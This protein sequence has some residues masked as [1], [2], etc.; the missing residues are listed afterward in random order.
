MEL[1]YYGTGAGYGIPEMFCSC[2][3]CN[4]AR[5]NRG[6]DIRTRS[7]AVLDNKLMIDF[8]VDAFLH[9]VFYDLDIREI[10]NV[11]ITHA[12][13]D[14]FLETELCTRPE[15]SSGPH[16]FYMS[17][18]SSRSFAQRLEAR[19]KK[20]RETL[21]AGIEPVYRPVQVPQLHIIEPFK[22]FEVAQ[23]HITPLPAR[24]TFNIEPMIYIIESGGKALLWAHD[25]GLF[26]PETLEFLRNY[27]VRFDCISL[28]CTLMRQKP[29]TPFHMD[30]TQCIQTTQEL[31][32][33][34]RIDDNTRIIL[35]HIGHL[36]YLTHEE[37]SEEARTYGMEVAYDLMVVD[38]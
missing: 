36:V 13:H 5:K 22:K 30:L 4:A 8:P 19:A 14:H 16:H 34:G 33:M 6:K 1:I 17:E 27:S 25:T 20:Q 24:H 11:I 7:Q 12:H 31:R 26:M 21:E 10:K 38:I 35:S 32:E 37:L 28:D 18:A 15:D 3:V 29:I 2:R 9:S 23:Y